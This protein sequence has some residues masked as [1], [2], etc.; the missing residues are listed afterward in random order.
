MKGLPY[1]DE[2]HSDGSATALWFPAVAISPRIS[3]KSIGQNTEWF[4]GRLSSIKLTV[5]DAGCQQLLRQ[6]MEFHA[7]RSLC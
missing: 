7:L 5:E 2:I 4:A 1:R 6:S 3:R